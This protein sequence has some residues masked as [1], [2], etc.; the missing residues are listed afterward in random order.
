MEKLC[1]CGCGEVVKN[2][3]V[4]YHQSRGRKLSEE[5]KQNLRQKNLGKV[6]PQEV[7]EKISKNNAKGFLGKTHSEETRKKLSTYASTRT[8]R[9]HSEETK[10]KMSL[11]SK[12]KPKSKEHKEKLSDAAKVRQSQPCSEE[13]KQ[14]ISRA[15]RE[16]WANGVY[17][18]FQIGRAHV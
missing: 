10:M 2:K 12:G 7:R 18:N 15:N 9:P 6:I 17:D 8:R 5:A 11:A 14:K 4:L 16:N 1:G 3:F 13:T